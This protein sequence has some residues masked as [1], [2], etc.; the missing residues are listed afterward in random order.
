VL[1]VRTDDPEA[2]AALMKA[3]AGR[4]ERAA[5]V[6][7][8]R[9]ASRIYG[10]GI[11]MLGND[12]SAQDL[13]Q[14]TFVKLVRTAE[15]FDPLRGRLETWVLLTARSLA[16]DSL[17]RRVLESRSLHAIGVPREDDPSPGPEE[18]ATVADLYER[19]AIL[20]LGADLA[21]EHPLLSFQVR[22]MYS[23]YRSP[24]T[25][26]SMASSAAIR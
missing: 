26:S 3:F 21:L 9:F 12:S 5:G 17:R 25:P 11:V 6:L 1:R 13:V 16:I 19:K 2:D 15:R 18:V 23:L 10:L 4:D 22:A 7:Y 20:V 8:D 24:N 14:D